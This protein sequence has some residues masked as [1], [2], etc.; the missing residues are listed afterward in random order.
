MIPPLSYSRLSTFLACRKLYDYSYTQKL[1]RKYDVP[2]ITKGRLV[3][4]GLES[5]IYA[6]EN[7]RDMEGCQ[8]AAADWI[9]VEG[10]RWLESDEVKAHIEFAC[11]KIRTEALALIEEAQSIAMR[12]VKSIGIGTGKWTTISLPSD[13][14]T[15]S[16]AQATVRKNLRAWE[17]GFIGILDWLARDEGSGY[18]W[19]IDFKC[20]EQMQAE[21]LLDYDYQLPAYQSCVEEMLG[22]KIHGCAHWQI[23]AT[24]ARLPA[25]LKPR[26]KG[27]LPLGLA[28]STIISDWDTYRAEVIRHGF[29]PDDYIEMKT[30]MKPMEVF[31]PI[32]RSQVELDNIWEHIE[33][34][35]QEIAFHDTRLLSIRNHSRDTPRLHVMQCRG[36]RFADLCLGE[37]RG[38]DTKEI[39][40]LGYMKK[41][42]RQ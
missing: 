41:K 39:I 32:I 24:P 21:E 35:A 34:A 17:S 29:N 37:L 25:L 18:E 5:S 12:A 28:R 22:R 27:S 26:K 40:E 33:E 6:Q 30:K 23:R 4:K 7:G 31:T 19:V 2:R 9:A 10:K 38:H 16:G 36:C 13:N 11:E 8:I 15:Q 42:D 20:R 14:G 3:D 1:T